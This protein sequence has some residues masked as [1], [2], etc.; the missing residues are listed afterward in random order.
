MVIITMPPHKK[1]CIGVKSGI[2]LPILSED[3]TNGTRHT[4]E[5]TVTYL[6]R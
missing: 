1:T 4:A 2:E 6:D 5:P 3:N